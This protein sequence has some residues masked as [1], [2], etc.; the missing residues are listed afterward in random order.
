MGAAAWF[1]NSLRRNAYRRFGRIRPYL[2]G[3]T[4]L[5]VGAAE[6][7]IGEAAA[8]ELDFEVDLVDVIDLNRTN[9]P[10]R[11]Y[12]GLRL[13]FPDK[14][15]DTVTLLLTLHHC[16]EPAT[17]LA[18]AAR[19]ARYRIVVTESVYHTR[20]GRA[21]LRFMD[22]GLNNTRSTG[23]MAPALH[24]KTVPEWRGL[25]H[26]HG[27]RIRDE[28]WLSRGLHWQRLFVLDTSG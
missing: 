3:K 22:G 5:D 9:L 4:L 13:P 8:S 2:V 17:V 6:G 26:E 14:S 23:C 24:F 10:H 25:F 21:L 1:S 27:L 7:W 16:S 12:D 20:A 11:I 19:V 15:R 18:E 28:A